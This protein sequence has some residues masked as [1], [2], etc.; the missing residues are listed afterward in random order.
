M[1]HNLLKVAISALS[2]ALGC[3]IE[4]VP[5]QAYS[6]NINNAGFETPFINGGPG[7]FATNDSRFVFNGNSTISSVPG[8]SLYNPTNQST[9]SSTSSN[10]HAIGFAVSNPSRSLVPD[11]ATEG[12]QALALFPL[13]GTDN[14]A[15]N[16]LQ[17]TVQATQATGIP[18][19]N[20]VWGESQTLADVLSPNTTYTLSVDIINPQDSNPPT[21]FALTGFAGYAVQLLAGNT[22]LAQDINNNPPADAQSTTST[23]S[24][25]AP[26]TGNFIGQ[27]L[28]IRLIDL[29]QAAGRDVDFDNVRLEATPVPEPSAILGILLV[30]GIGFG[31]KRSRKLLQ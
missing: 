27:P 15:D 7:N 11:G 28:Q 4:A 30:G 1:N 31:L 24:Y 12:N 29:N 23:I 9:S 22:I 20:I 2:V 6:L 3:M 18:S 17:N 16:A 21:G 25:A 13:L 14:L 10:P 8:W 5:A 26:A 19:G